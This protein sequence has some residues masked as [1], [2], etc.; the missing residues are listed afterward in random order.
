MAQMAP[1][2]A[3]VDPHATLTAPI[4]P[5]PPEMSQGMAPGLA[6]SGV[7]SKA[8]KSAPAS[9]S[10]SKFSL[11]PARQEVSRKLMADYQKDQNPYGS[12][13]N[14]PGFGGKL[15]HVLS[16]I[17]NTAGNIAS[18]TLMSRIPGT[19]LH[20]QI[21]EGGLQKQLEDISKEEST[22]GLQGAQAGKDVADTGKTEAETPEVAPDAAARR[23]LEGATAANLR[24]ETTTRDEE[25]ANPSMART[26]DFLVN[27]ALKENRDPNED[28]VIKQVHE[29]M[30]KAV[31]PKGAEHINVVG[32]DGKTPIVANY[33]PATHQTTD[34]AGHVI[35]N[36]VPYEP[37]NYAS[38]L[39]LVLSTK[40]AT[41]IDPETNLPTEKQFN[42][43]T[44]TFDKPLGL[45]ASNAYG[46]E[47]A[48][49]GAV[50]RSANDLIH[51]IQT[52]RD[53]VGSVGAWVQ[54]YGLNT[55]MADPALE[56]IRAQIA[57]FAALNPAMHGARGA[58]AMKHFEDVIGGV[59]QNPDATIAGIRGIVRGAAQPILGQN[60]GPK[61]G[62]VE[63]GYRFKGGNASDKNNWEKVA[64]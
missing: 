53:K 57:S 22:E 30:Q 51:T 6:D 16:D 11:E 55:P 58:S 41:Y 31:T 34:A 47:A 37:P 15:L 44:R 19:Q 28:P 48:Q 62:D 39:P 43:T 54:K 5:A 24:S 2:P 59:Q 26:L 18:P 9:P 40:T 35:A 45:S 42:P 10:M 38:M 21:E 64:H 61:V 46:H 63:G 33:D 25:R 20:R 52:N 8:E 36:P 29:L 27:K 14:H 7:T 23:G 3:P 60:A 49:A 56:G 4:G 1:P 50:E 13:N 12:A 32:P 17:G